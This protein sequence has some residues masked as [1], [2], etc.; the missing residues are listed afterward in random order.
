MF[1]SSRPQQHQQFYQNHYYRPHQYQTH[2]HPPTYQ[3]HSNYQSVPT[4]QWGNYTQHGNYPGYYQQQP[5]HTSKLMSAFQTSEGK[6]D[7]QKAMTTVDQVVKTANQ[8]SPIVKQV[9]SFFQ[10]KI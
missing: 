5:S 1:F 7:F 8:V 3:P 10:P 9:G 6:F 2:P 4:D